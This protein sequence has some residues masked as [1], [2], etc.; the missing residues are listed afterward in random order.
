MKKIFL[1]L[2]LVFG[3]T[4][5]AHAGLILRGTDT[6]GNQLI[7]DQDLDIT[8]YDVINWD[9]GWHAQPIWASELSVTFGSDA[10]TDWR[11]PT[12]DTC[13]GTNCI[14]SEM[15]HLYYTE[16]GNT[17]GG[18]NKSF[19]D[20]QTGVQESFLNLYPVSYWSGTLACSSWGCGPN[21]YSFS[22]SDGTQYYGGPGYN[23]YAMAVRDGNVGGAVPE[24]TTLALMGLG[25]AGIGYGRSRKK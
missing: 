13:V 4:L 1:T 18:L 9:A 14:G 11:L 25:L 10:Y 20:A 17:G 6:L 19:T 2:V 23:G 12:S 15:G 3:V 24:P 8:W 5:S 16:L 7:Y 21:V 22:F